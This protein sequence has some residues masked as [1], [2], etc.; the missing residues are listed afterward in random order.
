MGAN[1]SL[2][3][4]G[5]S[6]RAAVTYGVSPTALLQ[7]VPGCCSHL[8]V[9]V[10]DVLGECHHVNGPSALGSAQAHFWTGQKYCAHHKKGITIRRAFIVLMQDIFIHLLHSFRYW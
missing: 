6:G 1:G 3:T 10:E 4:R 9:W 8:C 5:H 2:R 7:L